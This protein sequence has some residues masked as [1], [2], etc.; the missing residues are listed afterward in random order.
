MTIKIAAAIDADD[1][2][3]V[4]QDFLMKQS[5]EFVVPNKRFCYRSRS[6]RGGGSIIVVI[7]VAF[8]GSEIT[9]S[10]IVIFI[11]ISEGSILNIAI[12]FQDD[13]EE[14]NEAIRRFGSRFFALLR[15]V[16]TG[17]DGVKELFANVDSESRIE[18]Q[19]SGG[20]RACRGV[21]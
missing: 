9:T 17:S 2:T 14:V 19:G 18:Q 15:R 12:L 20:E 5:D 4:I 3:T 1:S 16:G 10:T 6:M 7:V 8:V 21:A 13:I 11:L